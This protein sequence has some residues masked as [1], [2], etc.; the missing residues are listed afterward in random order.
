MYIGC[1]AASSS[2]IRMRRVASMPSST[3]ISIS[4]RPSS[5]A[6]AGRREEWEQL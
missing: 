4:W 2:L 3:G 6:E 5:E 1:L